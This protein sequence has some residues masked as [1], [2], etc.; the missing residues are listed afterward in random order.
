VKVSGRLIGLDYGERRIGTAVSDALGISARPLS[1]I[2]NENRER[3]MEAIAN[4]V[5]VESAAGLIVGLPYNEGNDKQAGIVREWAQNLQAMVRV[6]MQ[7]WDETLSSE[8]AAEIGRRQ[9]RRPGAPIDD[10]AAQ[11]ILQSFLDAVHAGLVQFP[12]DDERIEE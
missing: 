7:F 9:K 10:I 4:L 12:G 8:E 5:A 1:I 2:R 3:T 6:P 11:V